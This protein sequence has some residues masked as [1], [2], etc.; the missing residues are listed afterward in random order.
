MILK[1][2]LAGGLAS[3]PS[4]MRDALQIASNSKSWIEIPTTDPSALHSEVSSADFTVGF[5]RNLLLNRN[6]LDQKSIK[7]IRFATTSPPT[8]WTNQTNHGHIKWLSTI[9]WAER[10]L[11][12]CEQI[13]VKLIIFHDNKRG[14][15]TM[16][17]TSRISRK[18][19]GES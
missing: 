14:N 9:F 13:W 19:I 18:L 1:K 2:L 10:K 15:V 6:L 12:N 3:H 8:P 7:S 16:C 17:Q 4:Q 11:K 5:P